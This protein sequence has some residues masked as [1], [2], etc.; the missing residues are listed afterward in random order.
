VTPGAVPPGSAPSAFAPASPPAAPAGPPDILAPR[1]WS[2]GLRVDVGF[3]IGSVDSAS[4]GVVAGGQVDDSFGDLF[5][6]LFAFTG[7]VGYRLTPHWYV[8]GYFTGAIS[9]HSTI[10]HGESP[11]SL[12][13]LRFGLDAKYIASPSS[14]VSP[15]IGAGFGWEIA[16]MSTADAAGAYY[17]PELLHLRTGLDFHVSP[18]LA[19]GPEAMFSFGVFTHPLGT[20]PSGITFSTALHDWLMLGIGGHYDL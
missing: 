13:D 11:C 20:E 18:H 15:W 9:T 8:G 14:F 2:F 6:T 10:C 17:G 5:G 12:N 1:G 7:D 19:I 4:G 16:N 3:P